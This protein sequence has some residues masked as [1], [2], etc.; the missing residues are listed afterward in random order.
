MGIL[1]YFLVFLFNLE[2]LNFIWMILCDRY[3]NDAI[4]HCLFRGYSSEDASSDSGTARQFYL[5][6][7]RGKSFGGNK[8]FCDLRKINFYVIYPKISALHGI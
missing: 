1:E 5:F 2:A 4:W 7:G 3:G 8:G 6:L